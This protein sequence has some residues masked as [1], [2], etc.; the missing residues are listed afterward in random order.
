MKLLAKVTASNQKRLRIVFG[1]IFIYMMAI[2]SIQIVAPNSVVEPDNFP[3]SCPENSMNCTLIGPNPHRGEGIMEIRFNSNF[4]N[5][6]E[7]VGLWSQSEPR[8]E[9]L[10]KWSNQIHIV[11]RSYL[12]KFPDDFIVNLH[13]DE[14]ETVM[15]IYSKSRLGIDDL[16]VNDDRV[17]KFVEH[18]S[19]VEISTSMCL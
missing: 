2:I 1:V 7:E 12:W 9:V 11:F 10:G 13:C 14:G 18:I 19:E 4:S 17:S 3:N 15:Y 16:G 6:M 8:T 5:I